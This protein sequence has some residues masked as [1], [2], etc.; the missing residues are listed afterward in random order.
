MTIAS[1]PPVLWIT[2]NSQTL[3]RPMVAIV[4]ALNASSLGTRMAQ[5]LAKGLGELGYVTVSGLAR[6]VD[7]VARKRAIKTGTVA[8]MAGGVDILYPAENAKL[9]DELNVK[10]L[11][12]R[13]NPWV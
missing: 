8:V 4:G 11:A 9:G 3:L 10:A 1:P 12:Y 5:Y 6:G 7:T 2:G 13:N